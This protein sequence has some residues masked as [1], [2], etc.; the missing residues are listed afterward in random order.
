MRNTPRP[1][2]QGYLFG[3]AEIQP[4][5][6]VE[7]A[8]VTTAMVSLHRRFYGKGPTR[9]KTYSVDDT[10][11]CILEGGFTTVERTLIEERDVETVLQVRRSFQR[12]MEEH[13]TEVVEKA[14]G[15]TVIAYM[16]QIHADPDLAVELFVLEPSG[17]AEEH[18]AAHGSASGEMLARISTD[19]VQLHSRFYGRGPTKAKTHL[20]DDTVF[21][22]LGGGFTTVE[23][24]LLDTGEA[25]SVFQ[26]RLSFQQAMDREFR[27]IVEE[28]T[29]RGVI[30]YMSSIHV[31]PDL[32]VE[33]F[34]LEA[35]EPAEADG[36][37]S[38]AEPLP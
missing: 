34:V 38:P 17:S 27:R 5:L 6:G 35:R 10:V 4:G 15:R 22:V 12:A 11:I 2:L 30:A 29:G 16:S 13:F 24:T 31:D 18:G 9:A 23:R 25:E 7:L 37:E 8:E 20:V 3:V 36:R 28:A 26:M 19:L 21:C 33:L 14:L 1:A 32:A